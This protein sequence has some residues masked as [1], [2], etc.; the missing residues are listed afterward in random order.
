MPNGLTGV[1][2]AKLPGEPP[3][4]RARENR[5]G[6]SATGSSG[7]RERGGE[8]DEDRRR[9]ERKAVASKTR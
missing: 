3:R 7:T 4:A 5:S 1:I 6:G 2:N 9:R 8:R